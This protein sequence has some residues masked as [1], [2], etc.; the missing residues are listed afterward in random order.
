M[1]FTVIP[2]ITETGEIYFAQ[3]IFRVGSSQISQLLRVVNGK[4]TK[5]AAQTDLAKAMAATATLAARQAVANNPAAGAP[6]NADASEDD[7]SGDEPQRGSDT[8]SV[9]SDL[10][11]IGG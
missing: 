3:F 1:S 8:D 5:P 2:F 10:D 11:R 7:F 4:T 6:G 9:R